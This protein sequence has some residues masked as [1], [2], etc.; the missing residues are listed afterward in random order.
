LGFAPP[1]EAT[2]LAQLS[3]VSRIQLILDTNVKMAF[4]A[5]QYQQW[6]AQRDI[7]KYG[8]WKCGYA[9]E[10][11][12]EHLARDGKV[13][14]FD[15]PIWTESPP[16]GEFNCHCYRL[17]LREEDVFE[18]GITPEPMDVPFAPSSLGFNPA[19]GVGMPPEFG[20]RVRK[21]YREI[22]E[23]QMAKFTRGESVGHLESSDPFKGN[24]V[25][26]IIHNPPDKIK[27]GIQGSLHAILEITGSAAPFDSEHRLMTQAEI[28]K[29]R[30]ENN[31]PPP[32]GDCRITYEKG[33]KKYSIHLRPDCQYPAFTNMHEMV[34]AYIKEGVIKKKEVEKIYQLVQFTK[35]YEENEEALRKHYGDRR[36]NE[37]VT[38]AIT[39][40]WM[41]RAINPVVQKERFAILKNTDYLKRTCWE[42]FNKPEKATLADIELEEEIM[43]LTPKT[44]FGKLRRKLGFTDTPK[45][46]KIPEKPS[47]PGYD[48]VIVFCG[49]TRK[50]LDRLCAEEGITVEEYFAQV[51]AASEEA[52]AMKPDTYPLIIM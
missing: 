31:G 24:G 6:A 11:R 47:D 41:S 15:H 43:K 7:Y 34:H 3:S 38:R 8:M 33:K 49:F 32:L 26:T 9:K 1:R 37:W 17:L 20:K 44:I 29:Y 36:I 22:A 13:Y 10:H 28:E 39:W 52:A 5:G 35:T 16:G 45:I 2:G 51:K 27:E 12:E 18:R 48:S 14:A 50:D 40:S 25:A 46:T 19:R 4:E 42:N 21:E 30:E 23:R